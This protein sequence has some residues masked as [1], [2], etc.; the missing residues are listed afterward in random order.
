MHY[1]SLSEY[2]KNTYGTKVYRLSLS[3]GCTCP[4]RDGTKGYGGCTFCSEGGS[5]EFAS[6]L[7]P[8]A[9]QIALARKAVDAKFPASLTPDRYRYIA[10]FQSYSNTYGNLE[11]LEQLYS[12]T[13]NRD[14]ILILDLATRPD[15]INEDVMAMLERLQKIKPVWVELGLQ[16]IHETSAEAFHR[17]YTLEEFETAFFRLREAGIPV[18]VHLIMNLPGETEEMMLD[19]V[20]YLAKIRPDGVKIHMLQIMKHTEIAEEYLEHPWKLMDLDEYCY[21]IAECLK[22]L[23]E[24]VVIHRLTG[25]APKRLLIEP[26]WCADKKKVLNTMTRILKEAQRPVGKPFSHP[27]I[28]V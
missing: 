25:D 3:S 18:I 28:G 1:L 4:N 17:G 26:Q 12:E 16:T 20:R 24:D 27:D 15:C 5:G 9:E 11:R 10:Y 13:V 8:A 7:L 22:I 21:F 2:M 6:P 23:P 14:E 19:S